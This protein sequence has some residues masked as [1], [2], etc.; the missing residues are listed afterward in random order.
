MEIAVL[1]GDGTGRFA[2]PVDSPVAAHPVALAAGDFDSDGKLDLVVMKAGSHSLSILFG[3]MA[4]AR[5]RR[6]S[7][8]RSDSTRARSRSRT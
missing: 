1:L 7:T 8:F 2:S 6:P 4:T 5:S 3:K